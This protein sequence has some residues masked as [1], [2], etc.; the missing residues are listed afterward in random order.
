M[1]VSAG[2]RLGPYEILG[3]IGQGGMGEVYKARDTRLDRLVAVK[4]SQEHFSERFEREARAVAALNHPHICTL[5]DVGPNYLVMEYVEGESPKG[6]LP[7][8]RAIEYAGQI[9]E[10]LDHAHRKGITHRDL[11]PAN[12]LVTKQGIKLLDFGL[13]KQHSA[14]LK[15]SDETL[16]QAL[17][18]PLTRDGQILGTLQYMSPEQL[19]GQEIDPR[20][21][22]FSF[23]CVL[24]EMLT[25]KRAFGGQSAASVIAAILE[26]P[27][28]SV[29]D[30]A[31]PALDRVLKRCLAKDPDQR[32]QTARDLKSALDWAMMPIG[33]DA[34]AAT[35]PSVSPPRL[36]RAGW[37]VA[38]TLV[39]AGAGGWAIARW[40]RPPPAQQAIRL[41]LNPPPGGQFLFGL[42]ITPGG[43]AVSPDGRSVAFVASVARQAGLWVQS[44]DGAAARLLPGSEEA[45]FPF[46]SPD[47]K[48]LA[49]FANGKLQ[50]IDLPVGAPLTI[51]DV[52]ASQR[53]GGAWS[54]DGYILLGSSATGLFRVP[55]SG[56]TPS[57]LPSSPLAALM[58]QVLPGGRVLSFALSAGSESGVFVS[59]LDKPG[60]SVRLLPTA[61][62]GLYAT[63]ASGKHYLLWLRGST[64]V[65]QQLDAESLKFIGEPHSIADP[66]GSLNGVTNVSASDN[67]LLIYAGS[68]LLSQFSWFDRTGNPLGNVAEPGEY[69][70]FR[71]AA[72][73]RFA[74]LARNHPQ[75]SDLW[76]LDTERGVSNR[77]T[78]NVGIAAY[79]VWSHDGAAVIFSTGNPLSL[80]RKASSG[81]GPEERLTR[82]TSFHLATDWSRDGR[83]AYFEVGPTTQEDIWTVAVTADGRRISGAE[84]KPYIQTPF[85]ELNAR[86]SP[87][88]S[89]RWIAYMSNKSGQFEVYIDSFPDPGHE[90]RVSSAGGLYPEWSGAGNELFYLSPDYRLMSVNLKSTA[91]SLEPSAP[92]ELFRLPAAVN[93]WSP[94][95]VSPNGQRF[96]VR[97]LPERQASQPLTV[98]VNWPALL[99]GDGSR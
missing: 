16:T 30:V 76:L 36:G 49:F 91:T 65:A 96:L 53:G 24:Y 35:V 45:A 71:L 6:P 84:P 95:Q 15:E 64:L 31:P 58:P 73:G 9:L 94:Y 44:L 10:A 2:T 78:A 80:F 11:K 46:W 37:I 63:A 74:V 14:P 97:A 57:R 90:V 55:V 26:R 92:R 51:C 98:I 5:H 61:S 40:L 34:P 70:A 59:P 7:V 42:G 86:F 72:D 20:S 69:N 18:R 33:P 99:E 13:A 83:L 3:L 56:G 25:G 27:A 47:S 29:A 89:P 19:Q 50:R 93:T 67:G 4:V 60:K 48:S 38:G 23:G 77:F 22:L 82:S 52:D 41:Q 21:D 12:I 81:I 39:L 62:S 1:P 32:F 28:P 87:E 88:P 8:E 43:M 17:S 85:R 54:N 68:N 79:P 75:G 66:V